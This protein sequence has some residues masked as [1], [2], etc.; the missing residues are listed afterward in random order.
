MRLTFA[1][2]PITHIVYYSITTI[3]FGTMVWLEYIQC[4]EMAL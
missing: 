1:Q 4:I 3:K 2:R